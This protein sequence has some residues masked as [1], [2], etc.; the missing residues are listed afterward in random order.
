MFVII[1]LLY[2]YFLNDPIL[3]DA[4]PLIFCMIIFLALDLLTSYYAAIISG[5]SDIGKF[6]KYKFFRN[7]VES[8]VVVACISLG[9][10]F[11]T[12]AVACCLGIIAAAVVVAILYNRQSAL[13]SNGSQNVLFSWRVEF[14]PMQ[15]KYMLTWLCGFL[16]FSLIVPIFFKYHGAATAGKVGLLIALFGGL[17]MFIYTMVNYQ[18]VII[19]R[20]WINNDIDNIHKKLKQ[21]IALVAIIY[22]FVILTI[23]IL[24]QF[25]IMTKTFQILSD[26]NLFLALCFVHVWHG[27]STPYVIFSNSILVNN[28]YHKILFLAAGNLVILVIMS[29]V[30]FLNLYTLFIIFGCLQAFILYFIRSNLTGALRL[31]SKLI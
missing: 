9:F 25:P 3:I 24:V 6:Y 21:N 18:S 19:S 13:H 4:K 2:F 28:Y 15:I 29:N 14:L 17:N 20:L 12:L 26:H 8:L 16:T 30:S 27:F 1:S 5:L 11:V 23:M 22:S 7:V 31:K 10:S